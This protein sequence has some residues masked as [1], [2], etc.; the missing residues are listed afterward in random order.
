MWLSKVGGL[1]KASTVFHETYDHPTWSQPP[2]IVS[3]A[4]DK[5][6]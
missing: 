1:E 3:T 2:E 5:Q 6:V 4:Y